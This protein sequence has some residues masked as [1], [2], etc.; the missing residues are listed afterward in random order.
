MSTSPAPSRPV[1][2]VL[3]D[4]PWRSL[5]KAASW[6][7]TGTLDTI[8]LSWLITGHVG[9]AIS[10]GAAELFTK[11]LLYYC[12]ERVWNRVRAGR[13]SQPAPDYQI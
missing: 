4:R 9:K 8:L 3:V 5:A 10:I 11:T 13:A 2:L 12:H 6:R 1:P 7:V